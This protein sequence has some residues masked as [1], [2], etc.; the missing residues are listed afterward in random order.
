MKTTCHIAY[1]LLKSKVSLI[2]FTSFLLSCNRTKDFTVLD[3]LINNGAKI[4]P[5][6]SGFIVLIPNL[7]CS[8]CV[9]YGINFSKKNINNKNI[10]FFVTSD[11]DFKKTRANFSDKE[12]SSSNLIFDRKMDT[13]KMELRSLYLIIFK[14]KDGNV[15]SKEILDPENVL[16]TLEKI[17]H[18][19]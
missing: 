4:D 10:Y 5:N 15:L 8:K 13:K 18:Q 1:S 6:F 19:I 14:L 3:A 17:Q 7:G 16:S 2:L 12:V 9:S 11:F